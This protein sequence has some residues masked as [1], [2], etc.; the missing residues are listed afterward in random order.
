MLKLRHPISLLLIALLILMG[1]LRTFSTPAPV[2]ADAPDV[3][4]S[5]DRADA[6]LRDLLPISRLPGTQ[7]KLNP[8]STATPCL[9]VAARL[10]I[11]SP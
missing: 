11:S 4:F 10:T 5:A 6:I 9:A 3:V 1:V 7:R 2:D 8:D